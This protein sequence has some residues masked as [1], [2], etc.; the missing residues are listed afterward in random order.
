[1]IIKHMNVK[2]FP[3]SVKTAS[4]LE[5]FE[6][7]KHLTSWFLS[8]SMHQIIQR[9]K[10]ELCT[11]YHNPNDDYNFQKSHGYEQNSYITTRNY[12]S[13]ILCCG[14]MSNQN[15]CQ[16]DV[17][18]DFGATFIAWMK[19]TDE[20]CETALPEKLIMIGRKW[21]KDRG[22]S[23]VTES[24]S[25]A[26]VWMWYSTI[27]P[28]KC[29]NKGL[30][31]VQKSIVVHDTEFSW[32]SQKTVL[33]LWT[34]D[35]CRRYLT[36]KCNTSRKQQETDLHHLKNCDWLPQK[37]SVQKHCCLHF[38]SAILLIEFIAFS[39]IFLIEHLR[40]QRETW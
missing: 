23:Q 40:C 5:T 15:K 38:I 27:A 31:P 8:S 22:N 24:L 21:I 7:L 18:G 35:G 36:E 25:S 28:T 26:Q 12:G 11:L 33:P 6:M 19:S 4:K 37:S 10:L 2:R 39:W 20:S 9:G 14:W 3:P 1:M 32:Q 34:N 30:R 13:S 17:L 29:S 16:N